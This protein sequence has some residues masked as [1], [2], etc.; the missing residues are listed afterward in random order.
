M[1]EGNAPKLSGFL[2]AGKP[3][4]AQRMIYDTV[5]DYKI[6]SDKGCLVS[7]SLIKDN[8]PYSTFHDKT[9]SDG[10]TKVRNAMLWLFELLSGLSQELPKDEI[11]DLL[12]TVHRITWDLTGMVVYE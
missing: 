9:G 4:M 5:W 10:A 6:E 3:I 2:S 8:Q 12:S 11:V 1:M 7:L